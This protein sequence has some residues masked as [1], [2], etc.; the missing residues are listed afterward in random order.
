MLSALVSFDVNETLSL[1]PQPE[2]G[3]I[4]FYFCAVGVH[5]VRRRCD[6]RNL[7]L[8]TQWRCSVSYRPSGRLCVTGRLGMNPLTT[9]LCGE[10]RT[11]RAALTSRCHAVLWDPPA[12]R[13]SSSLS[14]NWAKGGGGWDRVEIVVAGSAR[15]PP[16]LPEASLLFSYA[17]SNSI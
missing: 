1:L 8:M 17:L 3:I 4:P 12:H 5:W 10:R 11:L 16:L 2:G 9:Q 7:C 14:W 6:G 15:G 13:F